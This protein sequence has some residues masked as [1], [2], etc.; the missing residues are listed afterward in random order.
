[1]AKELI[2]TVPSAAEPANDWIIAVLAIAVF[3]M[4]LL[5]IIIWQFK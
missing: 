3:M 2:V 5:A 1:M 4:T